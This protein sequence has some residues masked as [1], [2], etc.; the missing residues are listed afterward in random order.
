MYLLKKKIIG[1]QIVVNTLILINIRINS[2]QLYNLFFL[3]N[4]IFN[5][6]K[7]LFPQV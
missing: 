3:N 1:I 7:V 2:I 6:T 5:Q 4:V